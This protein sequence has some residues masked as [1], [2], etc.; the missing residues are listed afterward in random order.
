MEVRNEIHELRTDVRELR[1]EIR[2]LIQEVGELRGELKGMKF[3]TG[4]TAAVMG[5]IGGFL[6]GLPN[7]FKR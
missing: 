2:R 3:W 4:L 6:A 7:M 1:N 5:G